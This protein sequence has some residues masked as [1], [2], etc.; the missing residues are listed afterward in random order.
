M[1]NLF[2][3][4]LTSG[5]YAQY[6]LQKTRAARIIKNVLADGSMVVFADPGNSRLYWQLSLT[7]LTAVEA[8]ILQ[9]HFEACAGPVRAF[10]FIDPTDNMLVW[11]SDLT[12]AAWLRPSEV[13]LSAG[14]TDPT[15]NSSAFTVTNNA[16]VSEEII[17]TLS[18]PANYHYCFSLYA[19]SLAPS[20]LA[21]V[22]RGTSTEAAIAY[23]IGPA[24]TRLVSAGEL[25][26]A[27]TDVTI[28]IRLSA[29]QQVTLYGPQLEPQLAPSRYR[30]T[31][32]RGGVYANAHWAVDDLVLTATAPNLF[33]TAFH[34][35]ATL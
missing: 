33:S 34:I 3:P 18:T 24:W 6:P 28:A 20:S 25:G 4:Q 30:A 8:S 9:A 11:S 21:L 16:A 26:D 29:G 1:A 14:A 19:K 35:E 7:E 17:Q 27:A 5:A 32:A 15:G 12:A 2:F 10:T 22:R 23:D 31:G 13:G